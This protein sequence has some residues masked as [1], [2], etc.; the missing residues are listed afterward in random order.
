MKKA[1]ENGA[2]HSSQDKIVPMKIRG[3]KSN[4]ILVGEGQSNFP[5]PHV[6]ANLTVGNRGS[7]ERSTQNNGFSENM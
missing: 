5:S 1:F 6:G 2:I 3:Q 4:M 7:L